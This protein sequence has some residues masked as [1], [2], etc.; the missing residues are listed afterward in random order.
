MI[1]LIDQPLSSGLDA[2]ASS[3]AFAI[4]GSGAGHAQSADEIASYPNRPLKL[5]VGFAP[6]PRWH[7]PATARCMCCCR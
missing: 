5:I 4:L 6:M 1:A 2:F 7:R 3:F